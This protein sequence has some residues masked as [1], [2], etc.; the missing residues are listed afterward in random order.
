[1]LP[2]GIGDFLLAV[3]SQE[4]KSIKAIPKSDSVQ[5]FKLSPIES[6]LVQTPETDSEK[7]TQ[8]LRRVG[9]LRAT[10][11]NSVVVNSR[12][13]SGASVSNEPGKLST[14]A[15][16]ST[17]PKV[18]NSSNSR[19]SCTQGGCNARYPESARQQR[20]EGRVEIAIDT[21]EQGNVTS[22]RLVRS[23]GNRQ[24]DEETLRQ[25][26][27]WKLKPTPT[28]R[29]GVS[30]ATEYALHGSCRFLEL[31]ERRRYPQSSKFSASIL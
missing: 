26:R 27:N 11:N 6:S 10:Q 24:L 21:D 23:S 9:K 1:M 17:P 16:T 5:Q 15:T 7:L 31:Q 22:V 25:A 29:Q 12:N 30:I 2:S 14:Q 3:P 13:G 8:C 18:N 4:D 19:P 28:A 20:I